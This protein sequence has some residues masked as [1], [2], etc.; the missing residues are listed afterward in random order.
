LVRPNPDNRFGHSNNVSQLKAHITH[1]S[2]LGADI[3]DAW[4]ALGQQLDPKCAHHRE[5]NWSPKQGYHSRFP[6]APLDYSEC[7]VPSSHGADDDVKL[8]PNNT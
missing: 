6:T 2:L 5:R 8:G 4:H 7:E 1:F 3:D